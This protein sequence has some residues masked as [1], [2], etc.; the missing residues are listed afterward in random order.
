MVAER[1]T[2]L[3]TVKAS[4]EIGRTHGETVCVAGIRLDGDEFRW[5][6]LFPVQWHWFWKGEHPKY[7]VIELEI[8]KHDK[9]QRPESYRPRLDTTAVLDQLPAGKRRA[10]VLNRLPQYTMCDLVAAKGWTRPS[11]GLVVPS[12]ITGFVREDHTGDTAHTAKMNRAAQGSLLAQ[13]APNLEFSP[14]TFKLA[15]RCHSASCRGHEQSIVDWEISEAWRN[16]RRSYP[17]DY[18]DRIEEKWLSL[19]DPA[20]LPALYVGNQHQAP[21]GFLVLGIARDVTPVEPTPVGPGPGDTAP[22]SSDGRSTDPPR[23]TEGRL[24]DL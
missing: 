15:Y 14:F 6:R 10:E 3:L 9:D 11:L 5:I 13:G 8:D 23:S 18:L 17:T 7:Q 22:R 2:V 21:Q 24:F 1:A 16:W 12:E 20:R 4:P 19:V